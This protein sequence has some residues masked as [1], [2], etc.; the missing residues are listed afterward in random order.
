MCS[1]KFK[2]YLS[3]GYT[4]S[5]FDVLC[6]KGKTAFSHRGN[7]RFRQAIVDLN[8]LK[9]YVSAMTKAHKSAIVTD[10]IDNVVSA[11]DGRFIRFDLKAGLY[12]NIS[13]ESARE[14]VGQMLRE[15]LIQSDPVKKAQKHMRRT[16]SQAKRKAGKVS[17]ET[18]IIRKYFVAVPP[19]EKRGCSS[20]RGSLCVV[21][22]ALVLMPLSLHYQ[23][24]TAWFE[25][26]PSRSEG[27]IDTEFSKDALDVIFEAHPFSRSE[28]S[29][30]TEF[31]KDALN[32]ISEAH[33]FIAT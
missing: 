32:V 18:D 12:Y 7:E 8:Y 6:A 23:S 24:S 25:D 16:I 14:K 10:I 19:E 31:S 5:S 3:A 29:I 15:A 28:D 26:G 30:D 11:K 33:P 9:Q 1:T 17:I 22:K 20:R 2:N 4:P 21:D 13:E 27:S